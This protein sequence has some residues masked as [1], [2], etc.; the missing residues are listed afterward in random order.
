MNTFDPIRHLYTIN[1]RPVPSVTQIIRAILGDAMWQASDWHM[2]RGTAVHACAALVARGKIFSCDPQIAG[3]V[4]ACHKFFLDMKPEVLE[5]EQQLYSASYQFAGTM[6]MR[7]LF[8]KETMMPMDT[9]VDWKSSLSEV[10]EIQAGGYGVMCPP[11][12]YGMIVALQEDG[13]YKCG[14]MF[15][16]E[17]RKQEFLAL[18]SVYA[19]RQRVGLIKTEEQ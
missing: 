16:L 7:C 9:I 15:K 17:R 8:L 19:I 11:S 13:N 6:D 4:V 2:N 18:R 12:K 5:V 3:Q 10:S 14:E 1:S